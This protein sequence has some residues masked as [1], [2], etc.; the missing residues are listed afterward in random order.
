MMVVVV[1]VVAACGRG[2]L[3]FVAVCGRCGRRCV[4]CVGG[5]RWSS[6]VLMVVVRK[7]VTTKH[8][9]LLITNK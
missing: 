7:A 3:L 8:C 1:V 6:C 9:L 2:R 5:R 4:R